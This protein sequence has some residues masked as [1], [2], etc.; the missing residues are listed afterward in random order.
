MK[1]NKTHPPPL[2]VRLSHKERAQLEREAG[3]QTLS[4]YVRQRLFGAEAAK[5]RPRIRRPAGD[6]KALAQ[7]LARLGASKLATSMATLAQAARSGALP[8]SEETESA[9]VRGAREITETKSMLMGALGIR[10]D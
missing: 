3:S 6:Q 5:D 8:V 7:I 10:E 9:L 4:A 2:T 1:T